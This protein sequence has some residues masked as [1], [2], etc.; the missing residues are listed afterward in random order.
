MAATAHSFTMA[1]AAV[2]ENGP[3]IST[4]AVY[5]GELPGVWKFSHAPSPHLPPPPH[6]MINL[7]PPPLLSHNC[8]CCFFSSF[9]PAK[10]ENTELSHLLKERAL[11]LQNE[12]KEKYELRLSC[13]LEIVLLNLVS[14]CECALNLA[15]GRDIWLWDMRLRREGENRLFSFPPT[16]TLRVEISVQA[17]LG[18]HSDRVSDASPSLP[19]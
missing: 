6:S 12:K 13:S 11:T 17:V 9:F 7:W 14:K 1:A 18:S 19:M 5:Q 10:Q 15:T 3:D 4:A 8:R 16:T 2:W